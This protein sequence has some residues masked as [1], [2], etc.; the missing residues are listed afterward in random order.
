MKKVMTGIA[1]LLF[2]ILLQLCSTGMELF[3]LTIGII[4]LIMVSTSDINSK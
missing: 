4:G 3:T 2:A 1:V